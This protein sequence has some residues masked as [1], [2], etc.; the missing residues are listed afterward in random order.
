MKRKKFIADTAVHALLA[1][2]SV[3]WVSPIV[4][5]ILTSFRKELGTY[6][7]YIIPKEFTFNNYINL[8][9]DNQIL[10]FKQWFINTFVIA[11]FTM[12]ISDV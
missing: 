2:L 6:K 11:L 8:F 4:Y 9:G 1:V 7:S 5:V 3:I 12:L 10:D